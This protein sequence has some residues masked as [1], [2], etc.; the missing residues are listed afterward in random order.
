ML[1]RM[2]WEGVGG[3][4]KK[5]TFEI[6]LFFYKLIFLMVLKMP[7]IVFYRLMHSYI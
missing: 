4:G 6:N 7:L 5:D 3:N 2:K 1:P